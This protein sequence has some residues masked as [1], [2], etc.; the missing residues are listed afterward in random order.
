MIPLSS[1][2]IS[3]NEWTY[4][5]DCLDT[6]WVSSAGAYVG[7]ME[8]DVARFTG[9]PF[10]VATSNGTTALH[11]S[12]L[13]AGVRA[14][15]LVLSPDITFVAPVNSIKYLG[16]DPVLIDSDP[17]TWQMDLKI[18]DSFLSGE[19]ETSSR[20]CYHLSS[21][22]R[23]GAILPV[24]V[25]GGLCDM[26]LL[27]EI[28][29]RHGIPVV[30]DATEALGS[31]YREKH[32]GTFGLLGCF[33]FNG[34]KIITTGGGGMVVTADPNLAKRCKHLTTQAKSGTGRNCS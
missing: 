2:N 18:L 10:A 22:K 30:E 8:E 21:G 11:I 24:H 29:G 16:A 28:S 3:G 19:T 34:N 23:I 27:M 17:Q 4:I 5:K 20:G 6:G 9:S 13:L 1:P 26:D 7:K 14:G 31:R 12:L 32:A 25:L 15:D 33:S